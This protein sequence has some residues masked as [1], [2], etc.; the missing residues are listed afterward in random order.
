MK[1]RFAIKPGEVRSRLGYV[2]LGFFTFYLVE[3]IRTWVESQT[4][5]SP[6]LI[7]T[8]GVMATLYFFEFR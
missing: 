6:I 4:S 5:I 2:L 7:G 1:N 3:P 8:I